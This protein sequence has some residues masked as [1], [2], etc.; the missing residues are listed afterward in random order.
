MIFIDPKGIRNTGN[1]NDE[2]IQFCINYI[3]DI[4]SEVEKRI[5]EKGYQEK[6]V[7]NS[8]IISV[9]EYDS[10]KSSFGSGKNTRKDFEEHN[11]IFQ[12]DN[13]IP[14]LVNRIV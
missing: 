7:L 3:K 8:F 11:I 6:L 10:I 13:Y 2:K 1:F 5:D 4:E 12:E 14:N 9:T